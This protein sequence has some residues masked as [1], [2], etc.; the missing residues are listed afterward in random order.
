ME[1]RD[2]DGGTEELRA[3]GPLSTR[4]CLTFPFRQLSQELSQE[5]SQLPTV[6]IL[7]EQQAL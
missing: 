2:G 6:T 4:P 5:P 3:L 1:G 7:G